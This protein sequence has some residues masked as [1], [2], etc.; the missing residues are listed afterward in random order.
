MENNENMTYIDYIN[1][2]WQMN[3][4]VEF[5]SDEAALYFY[6][7]HECNM[8]GW[9]ISFTCPLRKILLAINL[10]MKKVTDARNKLKQVGL[11]DFEEKDGSTFYHFI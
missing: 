3:R 11:I 2:F 9:S 5:S 10:S 8:Q 1:Q 4:S 6:L 7:L